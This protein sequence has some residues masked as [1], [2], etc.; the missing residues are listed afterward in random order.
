M[1]DKNELKLSDT[2]LISLIGILFDKIL[3]EVQK[4]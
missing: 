1:K 2:S 3:A 4:N